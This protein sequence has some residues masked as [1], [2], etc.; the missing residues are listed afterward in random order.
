MKELEKEAALLRI[1]RFYGASKRK[2]TDEELHRAGEN[3]VDD[4][5]REFQ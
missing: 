4:L 5:E 3:A 2:T 1:K